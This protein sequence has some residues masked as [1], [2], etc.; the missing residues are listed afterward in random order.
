MTNSGL[1]PLVAAEQRAICNDISLPK[2]SK[3]Q[4]TALLKKKCGAYTKN[5]QNLYSALLLL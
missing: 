5:A 1:I 3:V 4:S 2:N